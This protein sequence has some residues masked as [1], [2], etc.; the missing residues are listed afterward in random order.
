MSFAPSSAVI[1]LRA[2]A[3][4]VRQVVCFELLGLLLV[5]PLFAWISGAEMASSAFLLALLSL[6]AVLW[7]ALYCAGFD[8]LERRWAGRPADLRPRGLRVLHALGLEM[9]LMLFTLPVLMLWT[10]MGV[11]AALLA[12]AGL[13][14]FYAGY[15]YVYYLA[16]DRF[17][18]IRAGK[19]AI[20]C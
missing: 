17:F 2:P 16:Y 15:A 10:D 18:P 20:P 1:A 9:G 5:T 6:A 8:V 13:A 12:D 3:D 14:L 11:W 4:R 19:A 7:S